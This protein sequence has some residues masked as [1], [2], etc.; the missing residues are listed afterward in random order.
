MQFVKFSPDM[1]KPRMLLLKSG[2]GRKTSVIMHSLSLVQIYKTR[3]ESRWLAVSRSSALADDDCLLKK[4]GK[5]GVKA[6]QTNLPNEQQLG[7]KLRKRKRHS[8][9]LHQVANCCQMPF[10]FSSTAPLPL[11]AATMSQNEMFMSRL[12]QNHRGPENWLWFHTPTG[13]TWNAGLQC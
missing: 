9:G 12:L 1:P 11:C 13:R 8:L 6:L 5:F 7:V 4:T 3:T 10:P 2:L